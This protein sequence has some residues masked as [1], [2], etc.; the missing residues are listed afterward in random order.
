M[1]STTTYWRMPA[2]PS[3]RGK[4]DQEDS[5]IHNPTMMGRKTNQTTM[6]MVFTNESVV[7]ATKGA[8][9]NS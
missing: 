9:S 4:V 3:R 2:S 6:R 8:R 5:Q 1:A 7:R